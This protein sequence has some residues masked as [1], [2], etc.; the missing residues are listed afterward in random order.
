MS[1]ISSS[2]MFRLAISALLL[3]LC[4]FVFHLVDVPSFIEDSGMLFP[5]LSVTLLPLH[6][7]DLP[8][9]PVFSPLNAEQITDCLTRVRVCVVV[10]SVCVR[11]RSRVFKSD[12]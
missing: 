8:L 6:L 10:S 2:C 3:M 11:V 7:L 4:S 12:E 1:L 9:T 5:T